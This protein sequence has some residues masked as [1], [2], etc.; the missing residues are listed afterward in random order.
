MSDLWIDK[1]PTST[2]FEEAITEAGAV[3]VGYNYGED[4]NCLRED[5]AKLE[6]ENEELRTMLKPHYFGCWR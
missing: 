5:I 4:I 2:G 6:A 3:A 1:F